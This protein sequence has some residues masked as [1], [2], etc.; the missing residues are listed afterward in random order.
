MN[1]FCLIREGIQVPGF[2]CRVSSFGVGVSG[3]EFHDFSGFGTERVGFQTSGVGCLVPDFGFRAAG[4]G[5]R[6]PDLGLIGSGFHV[7]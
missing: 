5:S 7:Y 1:A 6:V 3:F 4:F 2:W